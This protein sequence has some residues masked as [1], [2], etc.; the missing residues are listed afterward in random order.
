MGQELFSPSC[1]P[2]FILFLFLIEDYINDKT[3]NGTKKT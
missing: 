1:F 3:L 2:F